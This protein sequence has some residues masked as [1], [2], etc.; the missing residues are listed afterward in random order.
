MAGRMK[1]IMTVRALLVLAWRSV[2]VYMQKRWKSIARETVGKEGGLFDNTNRLCLR[3]VATHVW[4]TEFT[5]AMQENTILQLLEYDIEE[6]RVWQRSLLWFSATQKITTNFHQ[7]F[8]DVTDAA[9]KQATGRVALPG[10]VSWMRCKCGR[11][12]H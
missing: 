7:K 10:T 3:V 2:S 8:D 4:V 11:Q 9:L 1:V 5:L 12:L 6:P